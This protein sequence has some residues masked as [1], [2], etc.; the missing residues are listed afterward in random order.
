M[1]Y[2]HCVWPWEVQRVDYTA[3]R[4]LRIGSLQELNWRRTL[5]HTDEGSREGN[6]STEREG[7][8]YV[9]HEEFYHHYDIITIINNFCRGL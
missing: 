1:H 8:V 2:S 7:T 3:Y 9:S 6:L 4:G 5:G